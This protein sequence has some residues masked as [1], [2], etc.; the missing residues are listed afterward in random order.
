MV[1]DEEAGQA[2]ARRSAAA[3]SSSRAR[4]PR[5]VARC[6]RRVALLEARAADLGELRSARVVL[7]ARDSGSRGRCAGRT[8]AA[9]P[10]APSPPPPRDGRRSAPPSPPAT[11]AR[12]RGCRAAAAR[13]RRASCAR[14]SPRTRPAAARARACARGRCR[15]P[16]TGRPSRSASAAR[17]RLSARSWRWNGRCSSTRKRV[18]PER[19]SSRRIVGSSRTPSRA[20]PLRQTSPSACSLDGRRASRAARRRS[21]RPRARR[22]CGACARRR[23]GGRGSTSPRS[24]RA[25]SR[26]RC[27]AAR[28]R[29]RRSP[30]P[31]IALSPSGRRLR[32]LHRAVDAVVVGQRERL[33]ALLRRR[34][35]QLVGQ[36]GAVEEREGGVGVELDVR[37]TNTCSHMSRP[38]R[39]AANDRRVPKNAVAIFQKLCQGIGR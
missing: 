19:A 17:P 31:W 16:R 7:R 32:E 39:P 30:R 37:H 23:A 28:R 11:R 4:A 27:A 20:Q 35:R 38:S 33:V 22:A 10:A 1:Q 9:R 15:S 5:A 21:A 2:E 26:V 29:R 34:R 13:T 14:G 3:R 25:T 6:P 8:S 12:A 18:A 24:R 36:R